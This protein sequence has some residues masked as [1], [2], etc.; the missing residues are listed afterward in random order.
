M[1]IMKGRVIQP[2]MLEVGDEDIIFV[3]FPSGGNSKYSLMQYV[4]SIN[5]TLTSRE[6]MNGGLSVGVLP[7]M[8]KM[9]GLRQV[10]HLQRGR[11]QVQGSSHEGNALSGW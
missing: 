9:S 5:C 4:N 8:H 3:M 2:Q 7:L 1:I 10:M 6:G 11:K